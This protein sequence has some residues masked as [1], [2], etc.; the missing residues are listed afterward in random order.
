MTQGDRLRQARKAAGFETASAAAKHMGLPVSTY[1]A[2]ENGQNDFSVA[3]AE[4]YAIAF[5][6]PVLWLLTGEGIG[7]AP[8][9]SGSGPDLP[10]AIVDIV[11]QLPGLH[12]PRTVLE[13]YQICRG[14]EAKKVGGRAEKQAFVNAVIATYRLI[15]SGEQAGRC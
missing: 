10:E 2:H 5:D 6:V 11:E 13:A 9:F 15:I 7:P 8:E 12:N 14:I 4:R 1:S 3:Q